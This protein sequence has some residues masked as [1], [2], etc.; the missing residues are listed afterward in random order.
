MKLTRPSQITWI[1][2]LIL[3]ILGILAY[4]LP[5]GGISALAFWLVAI[6]WLLLILATALRGL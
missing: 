4:L 1:L 2:A 6:G 5:L 3:G